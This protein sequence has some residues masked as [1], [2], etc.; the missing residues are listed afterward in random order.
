MRRTYGATAPVASQGGPGGCA[1]G[2]G[3]AVA[4]IQIGTVAPTGSGILQGGPQGVASFP[5]ALILYQAGDQYGTAVAMPLN[6]ANGQFDLQVLFA[7]T[8]L[9]ADLL[10]YFK[11]ATGFVA[12]V[13][14]GH[15]HHRHRDDRL[16]RCRCRRAINCRRPAPTGRS[17]RATARASGLAPRTT[18]PA[19]R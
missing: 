16:R 4:L 2:A 18:T 8:D 19:G 12:T 15:R 1:A 17:R 3:A 10:G 5:N 11:P 7:A 6:A 9:Y 13:T 14:R